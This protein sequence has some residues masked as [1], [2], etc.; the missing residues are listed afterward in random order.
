[1][2]FL[3]AIPLLPTVL[4]FWASESFALS[5]ASRIVEI[6]FSF[7]AADS[8]HPSTRVAPSYL[9]PKTTLYDDSCTQIS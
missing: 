5:L 9:E 2:G 3:V 4:S 6:T 7:S 1:M 8:V